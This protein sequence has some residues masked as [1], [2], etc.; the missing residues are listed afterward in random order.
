MTYNILSHKNIGKHVI[1]TTYNLSTFKNDD[2]FVKNNG[3]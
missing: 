3:L 2:V 1:L